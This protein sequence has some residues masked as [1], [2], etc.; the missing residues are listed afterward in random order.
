MMNQQP[1][2]MNPQPPM[3]NQQPPMMNPQ[4]PM[5]NQPVMEQN[6]ANSIQ[7]RPN[8]SPDNIPEEGMTP[9][10]SMEPELEPIYEDEIAKYSNIDR[11]D[12][13]PPKHASLRS[14]AN[15][16]DVN[17]SFGK[18]KTEVKV[19]RGLKP[20]GT[21]EKIGKKGKVDVLSAALEMQKSREKEDENLPKAP[22]G[23]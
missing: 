19:T 22:F 2:M 11:E 1:P 5:M 14:G 12:M 9:I 15:S 13:F 4:P 16:Y 20:N 8:I 7:Q 6:S 23:L 17:S 10:D 21:N 18:M 3:M